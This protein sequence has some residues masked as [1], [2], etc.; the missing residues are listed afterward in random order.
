MMPKILSR[1]PTNESKGPMEICHIAYQLKPMVNA[2]KY[3]I[4]IVE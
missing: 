2:A 1:I 3:P 4:L